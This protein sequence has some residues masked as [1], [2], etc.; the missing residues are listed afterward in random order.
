MRNGTLAQRSFDQLISTTKP[1]NFECERTQSS[2]E[3]A[4]EEG[5]KQTYYSRENNTF[6]SNK[7]HVRERQGL[8]ATRSISRSGAP[9]PREY[10]SGVR[11]QQREFVVTASVPQTERLTLKEHKTFRLLTPMLLLLLLLV[12]LLLLLLL[13][14]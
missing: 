2:R 12:L 13:L 3:A 9:V 4:L 14:V 7:R 5:V 10:A 1:D 11:F 6:A 8:I